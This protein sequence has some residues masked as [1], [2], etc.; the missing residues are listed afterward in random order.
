MALA[1]LDLFNSFCTTKSGGLGVRPPSLPLDHRD[2]RWAMMVAREP[3]L[4]RSDGGLTGALAACDARQW[5]RT[6]EAR[7][8]RAGDLR[9]RYMSR[10]GR[11]NRYPMSIDA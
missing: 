10:S 2:A 11:L 5:S 9:T 4:W 3:R 8:G 7:A 1:A 6:V